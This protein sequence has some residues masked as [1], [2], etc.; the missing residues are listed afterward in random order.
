MQGFGHQDGR[1][2]VDKAAVTSCEIRNGSIF[3]LSS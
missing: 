2:V 3:A 1:R